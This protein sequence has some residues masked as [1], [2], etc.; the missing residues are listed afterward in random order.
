MKL[1]SAL[2]L[3][4]FLMGY[5]FDVMAGSS[6][7]T[8]ICIR[9]TTSASHHI[10]VTDI[11]N[12]DW[13]GV[14]RPDH[15]FNNIDIT[16][17]E[18]ICRREEINHNSNHQGFTFLIDG[19]PTRMQIQLEAVGDDLYD[20]DWGAYT[21]FS[22]ITALYGEKKGDYT[23]PEGWFLGYACNSGKLCRLFELR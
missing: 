9:N 8:H 21:N 19:N 5:Y 11:N 12:Y 14:D 23:D 2:M 17:G 3:S 4:F 1:S 15:N 18:T 6:D 20:L 16:A 10:Q 22:N 7:E 13:D